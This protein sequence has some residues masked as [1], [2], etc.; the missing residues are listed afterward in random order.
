MPL[1]YL[2]VRL[3]PW[4]LALCFT[5]QLALCLSHGNAA[6][7]SLGFCLHHH[8]VPPSASNSVG[9]AADARRVLAECLN[10]RVA[11]TDEGE[12]GRLLKDKPK[13]GREPKVALNHLHSRFGPL[14]TQT[15]AVLPWAGR[16]SERDRPRPVC[17]WPTEGRSRR[18]QTA[19]TQGGIS[20]GTGR[21][22]SSVGYQGGFLEEATM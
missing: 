13:Q 20:A 19:T 1:P 15:R 10:G 2:P 7:G 6:S 14:T 12:E 3:P 5:V 9:H 11:G 4:H 21:P 22:C 16:G 17:S 8:S 18:S